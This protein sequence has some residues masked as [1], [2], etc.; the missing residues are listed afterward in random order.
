M[1]ERDEPTTAE[2]H[3]ASR[4]PEAQPARPQVLGLGRQVL[5]SKLRLGDRATPAAVAEELRAAGVE[6]SEDDLKRVWD[7]TE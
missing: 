6:V 2:G 5:E 7:A 1:S 4:D 3:W